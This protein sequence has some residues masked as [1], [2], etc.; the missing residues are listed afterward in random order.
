MCTVFARETAEEEVVQFIE[1]TVRNQIGELV[2][3]PRTPHTLVNAQLT[4]NGGKLDDRSEEFRAKEEWE[5]GIG[6]FDL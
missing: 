4:R 6:G 3:L 5:V 1:D 2:R